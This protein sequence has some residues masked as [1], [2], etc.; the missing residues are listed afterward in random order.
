MASITTTTPSLRGTTTKAP[1]STTPAITCNN[2]KTKAAELK[3]NIPNGQ[4]SLLR[5]CK[6]NIE[7]SATNIVN[8]GNGYTS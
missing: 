2:V 5:N 1:S 4:P 8:G 7:T 6:R 3:N